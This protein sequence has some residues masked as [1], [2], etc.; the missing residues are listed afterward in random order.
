MKRINFYKTESGISPIEEFLDTLNDKQ[1]KKI[2][3]VLKLIQEFDRIPVQ[4]FKKLAN[5]DNIWE[6]RVTIA[7]NIFRI[8]CFFDDKELIILTNSFQ[9]KTQKTPRN[10]I[11]IAEQ[12]KKDYIKRK[13]KNG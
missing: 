11:K 5:T 8:L 6:V 7:G 4:Y 2:L 13:Q 10:E 3:W 9:K 1:V 12:R